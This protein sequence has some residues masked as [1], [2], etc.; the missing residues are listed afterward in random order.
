[1]NQ[2]LNDG[3]SLSLTVHQVAETTLS[4]ARRVDANMVSREHYLQYGVW[5]VDWTI[6]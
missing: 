3:L 2:A 5:I 1:M 4:H 6:Y